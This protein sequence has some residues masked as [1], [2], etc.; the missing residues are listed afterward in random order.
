MSNVSKLPTAAT[1]YYTVSKSG[2]Y[3]D[4]VLVTPS[5]GMK[6]IKTR[7]YRFT[8]R[9]AAIRH[10]KDTAAKVHRPFKLRGVT[11]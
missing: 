6:P 8:D 11:G 5:D 4:V 3:S 9:D 10:G 1:S 7:L 2:R